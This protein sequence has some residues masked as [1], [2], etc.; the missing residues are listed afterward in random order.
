MV[1]GRDSFDLICGSE[2][3][4]TW[5][6]TELSSPG[7][8]GP[9][10]CTTLAIS[11]WLGLLGWVGCIPSPGGLFPPAWPILRRRW[12]LGMRVLLVNEPGWAQ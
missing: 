9:G 1:P 12:L 2:R 7:G 10:V 8:K 4:S 3:G 5:S 6:T 11:H